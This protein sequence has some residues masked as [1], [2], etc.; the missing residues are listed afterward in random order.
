MRMLE[1]FFV[2]LEYTFAFGLAGMWSAFATYETWLLASRVLAE[3]NRKRS[4][5][6]Q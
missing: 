5:G 6:R 1:L 4:G 3:W 2:L